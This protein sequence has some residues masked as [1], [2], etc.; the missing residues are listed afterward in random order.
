MVP[1]RQE[2]RGLNVAAAAVVGMKADLPV[3]ELTSEKPYRYLVQ[4]HGNT[5]LYPRQYTVLVI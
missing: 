3:I 1:C 2:W 4:Y 5:I